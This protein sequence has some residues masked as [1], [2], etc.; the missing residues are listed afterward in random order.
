MIEKLLYPMK[1]TIFEKNFRI[2]LFSTKLKFNEI[3]LFEADI[4]SL[5]QEMCIVRQE[6]L[7]GMTFE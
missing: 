1:L 6:E 2:L 4:L 7:N 3:S 5:M